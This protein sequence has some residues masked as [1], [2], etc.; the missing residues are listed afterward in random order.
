MNPDKNLTMKWILQSLPSNHFKGLIC[1]QSSHYW[2]LFTIW[3]EWAS[4]G[5]VRYESF[6]VCTRSVEIRD[7]TG[8]PEDPVP[9]GPSHFFT[10]R[11][12]EEYN[13]A[14]PVPR[15]PRHYSPRTPKKHVLWYS[16]SFFVEKWYQKE[17]ISE[18]HPNLKPVYLIHFQIHKNFVPLTSIL[19]SDT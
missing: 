1:P 15:G 11:F 12:P 17:V 4:S 2:P 7:A 9:R 6:A 5:F 16:T 14:L 19:N 18:I 8:N 10:P 13:L 3:S